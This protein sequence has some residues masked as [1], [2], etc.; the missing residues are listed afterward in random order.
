MYKTTRMIW[1]LAVSMLSACSPVLVRTPCVDTVGQAKKEVEVTHKDDQVSI[2]VD[3]DSLC[4]LSLPPPEPVPSD[5]STSTLQGIEF[6][7]EEQ[8]TISHIGDVNTTVLPLFEKKGKLIAQFNV[9]FSNEHDFNF[10]RNKNCYEAHVV[11][12]S[13]G[14]EIVRSPLPMSYFTTQKIELYKK[15]PEGNFRKVGYSDES[16]LEAGEYGKENKKLQLQENLAEFDEEIP[17]RENKVRV[18]VPISKW[19]IPEIDLDGTKA[20]LYLEFKFVV[21]KSATANRYKIR[22]PLKT[23]MRKVLLSQKK[24]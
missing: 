17:Y 11:M 22:V 3:G 20:V 6:L 14:Q 4:T 18:L 12:V 24:N 13:D 16:L 15:S 5:S 7:T 19:R 2:W 23:D 10:I 1:F 21:D 8:D 9:D